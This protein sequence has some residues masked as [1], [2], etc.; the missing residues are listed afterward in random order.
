[1]NA[2]AYGRAHAGKLMI[3]QREE[4]RD[5]AAADFFHIDS[6]GTHPTGLMV[7]GRFE[8]AKL[9]HMMASAVREANPSEIEW[10]QAAQS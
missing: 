4:G 10:W 3:I 5:P 2:R 7:T 8:N 6:V 9:S 1:M